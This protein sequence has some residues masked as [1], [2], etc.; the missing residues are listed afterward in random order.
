MSNQELFDKLEKENIKI[1]SFKKRFLA[2][3][4]DSFV[5]FL[6]VSIILLDKIYSVQTY[7]EIHNVLIRF[8]GGILLLQF[9]YHTLFSYLYGATLGKIFLKIMIVD[10]N[11]LDKPNLTQSTLRSCFRQFS[12]MLYGLGFAWA[13]SNVVLK[14]WHDYVAK[15][16]VIDLA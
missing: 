7:D 8:A 6:I 4:I 10:Q 5:V 1:A 9:C 3:I 13:L 16:V 14:T 2:Y 12:D 15:T 11:L